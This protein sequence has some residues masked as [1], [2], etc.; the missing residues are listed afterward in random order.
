MAEAAEKATKKVPN[1][2]VP[3]LWG[4]SL[5]IILA[6]V[7]VLVVVGV[8]AYIFR[9]VRSGQV[10]FKKRK[11]EVLEITP[12]MGKWGF[13]VVKVGGRYF[14]VGLAEGSVNLI[15]ELQEKDL[16]EETFEKVLEENL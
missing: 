16:Q 2:E 14:L 3:S 6:L 5:R 11:V 15:S 9:K 1:I 12:V 13:A 7:T 10:P 8:F 4:Y